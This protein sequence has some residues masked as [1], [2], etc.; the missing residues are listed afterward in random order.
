MSDHVSHQFNSPEPE[1]PEADLAAHED[2]EVTTTGDGPMGPTGYS[3]Q[4]GGRD[5][6]DLVRQAA[7]KVQPFDSAEAMAE[8]WEARGPDGRRLVEIDPAYRQ[9]VESRTAA[10]MTPSETFGMGIE[11]AGQTEGAQ[12]DARASLERRAVER[13]LIQTQP[14]VT[15][16]PFANEDEMVEALSDPRYQS[17]ETFR[18]LVDARIAAM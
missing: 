9:V 2:L 6:S 7:G 18:R 11:F 5:T 16:E 8:A 13:A 3:V 4:I 17:S 15:A 10:A 14:Q 1:A 12:L